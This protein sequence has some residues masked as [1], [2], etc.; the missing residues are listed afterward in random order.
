MAKPNS[1]AIGL[2]PSQTP[3]PI[4]RANILGVGVSAVNMEMALATIDGWIADRAAHYV[5]VTPV[6]S[7]MECYDAPDVRHIYNRAGMV[8]PDGMPVVWLTRSA[9]HPHVRRV[10]GPDLMLALCAHSM[11]RGYRHYFYGG[12]DGVAEELARTLQARF[13]GLAVAGW[14][15]PPFRDLSA[16][17]D[18]A[19]C[20]RIRAAQPDIVWVGLGAPKQER[21]MAGHVTQLGVPALIGVGAAF[22]FLTGRKPQAPRWMQRSGLEWLF[23]LA[24]EPRRLFRRYLSA[25]SR[26]LWLI[27]LQR[28]GLRDFPLENQSSDLSSTV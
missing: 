18:A 22:D 28:L 4:P 24:S 17:E 19:V 13:P 8:T 9:G 14:E 25:N 6:H 23:R 1:T 11:A 10:Y 27:A 16:Q 5:C 21:W 12:A 3:A 7:I 20:A 2:I 15:S 26:F